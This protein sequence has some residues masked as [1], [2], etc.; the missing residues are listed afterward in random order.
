[1]HVSISRPTLACRTSPSWRIARATATVLSVSSVVSP[2]RH[3]CFALPEYRGM[4]VPGDPS[5]PRT[6][7]GYQRR[8]P[9]RERVSVCFPIA[10][11]V[12]IPFRQARIRSPAVLSIS[13]RRAE[14]VSDNCALKVGRSRATAGIDENS[15]GNA[16]NTCL[17]VDIGGKVVTWPA[18]AVTVIR[19]V[20]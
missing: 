18:A 16:A 12:A 15:D 4:G 3:S 14:D 10:S 11:P 19:A 8:T 13:A 6:P 2:M 17:R 1:M 7:F 20:R 5:N 9:S